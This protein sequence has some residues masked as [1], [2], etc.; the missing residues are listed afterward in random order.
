MFRRTL[1]GCGALLGVFHG[2]LLGVQ[3]WNGVL[4]EP[5]VVLRWLAALMLGAGLVSL[6]RR[7]ASLFGRQ[8]AAMWV[9]A[10]LLHGPAF[11][12]QHDGFAMP[13]LPE[14]VV[15]VAQAAVA[16]AT[17]GLTLV[18]LLALAASG[19]RPSSLNVPAVAP[20]THARRAGARA[21]GFLPRPP[22]RS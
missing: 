15:T 10:A 12:N 17:V 3:A 19:P 5:D 16:I 6:A 4:S 13:A 7:G 14:A 22:P 20:V 21:S 8:A 18:V 2:W 9:L 11:G 1:I